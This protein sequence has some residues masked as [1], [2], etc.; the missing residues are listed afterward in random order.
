MTG[1]LNGGVLNPLSRITIASFQDLGYTVDYS[2]A[3]NYTRANLGV[4]CTC[5]HRSLLNMHHGETQQLGLGIATTVRHIISQKVYQSA[6]KVGL[7]IL[8]ERAASP[9]IRG[10]GSGLTYIGDQIVSILIQDGE[11]YFSVVV[12]RQS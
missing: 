9:E 4:N 1:Y 7:S 5:S 12:K 6:M 10:G 11:S 8:E 3:D 2:T